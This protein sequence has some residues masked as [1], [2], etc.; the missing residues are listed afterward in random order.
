VILQADRTNKIIMIMAQ[1][2]HIII[3]NAPK[4]VLNR[5]RQIGLEKAR[6]LQE[7]KEMWKRGDLK[8]VEVVQCM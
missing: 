3:E 7:G 2:E 8:G 6:R 4:K 1:V 5:L